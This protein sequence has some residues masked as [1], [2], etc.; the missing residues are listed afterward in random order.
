MNEEEQIA[1]II[2]DD[3]TVDER[4]PSDPH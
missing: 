2:V 3:D 1:G 4:P